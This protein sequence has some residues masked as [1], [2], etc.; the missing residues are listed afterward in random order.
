[1]GRAIRNA[2]QADETRSKLLRERSRLPRRMATRLSVWPPLPPDVYVRRTTTLPFPLRDPHCRLFALGRHALWHGVGTLGLRAGDE[3]LVPAYHHGSEVEVL[4]RRGLTCRFYEGSEELEPIESELDALVG[5]RTRALLLIHYL[6]FPQRMLHW[7]RWCDERGLFLI[8]DAAQAW[9]AQEGKT[10]VGRAGDIA[11]FCLYK[12]FGLPA[13]AALVSGA[14]GT[15]PSGGSIRDVLPIARRH[16]AWARARVPLPVRSIGAHAWLTVNREADFALGEPTVQPGAGTSFLLDRLS[17]EAAVRHRRFNY[18][19]L[20]LRLPG[21]TTPPF[22]SLPEGASPFVFPLDTER[23]H[24]VLRSLRAAG[25]HAFDFWSSGHPVA[26]GE[27]FE[28]VRRRRERTVGLPVH[29][30]LRPR[31]VERIAAAANEALAAAAGR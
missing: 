4:V 23:K 3:V 25:I 27:R 5:Q 8:E 19:A 20:L 26:D 10:P 11:V 28:A 30:E 17:A 16:A 2:S 14:G 18:K 6:G 29:Q 13:G 22:D 7:R 1:M 15:R 31:D 9:L 21:A 12:T 24:E